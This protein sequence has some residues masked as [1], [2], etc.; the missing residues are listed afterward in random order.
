[1]K[2]LNFESAKKRYNDIMF[3]CC[4]EHLT[5]GTSFSEDTEGWN[6]RDMVAECD[7]LLDKYFDPSTAVGDM[8]YSDD[9]VERKMWLNESNRLKRFI[10]AYKPFVANM[11]C[12]SGHCSKIDN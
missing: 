6:I 5:I 2:H 9:I 1:M 12:V 4:C 7:Y 8:H 11:K 3:D 10:N